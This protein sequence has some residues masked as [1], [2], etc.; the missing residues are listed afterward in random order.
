MYQTVC[1]YHITYAF[2][3]ESTLYSCLNVRELA[4]N[5]REIWGLSGCNGTRTHNHLVRKQIH[6]HLGL[7][8]CGFESRCSRLNF[9]FRAC[10]KQGVSWHLGNYREWIY[11]ETRTWHNKNIESNAPYRQV[12]TTQLNHLATLAEWLSVRLRTKRLGSS[13]VASMY[14]TLTVLL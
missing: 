2:H 13:P 1:S 3:Y 6:N 9:R 12:L 8:G 5:R 4:R 14:H 10:F 11:S 7:S